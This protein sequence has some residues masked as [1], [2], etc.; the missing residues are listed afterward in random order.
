MIS[1]EDKAIILCEHFKPAYLEYEAELGN[2]YDPDENYWWGF[3][4]EAPDGTYRSFDFR[5]TTDDR[6]GDILCDVIPCIETEEGYYEPQVLKA[7]RIL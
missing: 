3:A 1:Q 7:E 4:F 6:T 5:F 2:G